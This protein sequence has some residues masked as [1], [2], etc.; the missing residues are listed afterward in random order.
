LSLE[1]VI[2]LVNTKRN[3]LVLVTVSLIAFGLMLSAINIP[4]DIIAY[5][6]EDDDDDDDDNDK[7]EKEFQLVEATISDIHQAIQAGDI[8]CE[9]LVQ[10]YI[11]RAAAFSGVCTQLV[12]EDGA[13]VPAATGRVIAGSAHVYPTATIPITDVVPDFFTAPFTGTEGLFAKGADHQIGSDR[14]TRARARPSGIA[15]CIIRIASVASP[16]ATG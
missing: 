8:T 16:G 3:K 4:D 11:D 5:A 1:N 15:F 9:E 14:H 10:A 2:N 12:T 7:D 13:S 6:N